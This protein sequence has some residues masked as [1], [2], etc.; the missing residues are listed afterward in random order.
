MFTYWIGT[1]L[2]VTIL[3]IMIQI[4]ADVAPSI[5]NIHKSIII[6]LEAFILTVLW[7][8]QIV[9]YIYGIIIGLK[10]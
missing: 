4:V 3:N 9:L 10:D 1:G 2:I 5:D 7:P 6:A 8:V